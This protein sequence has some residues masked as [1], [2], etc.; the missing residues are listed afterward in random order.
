MVVMLLCDI[1]V[2]ASVPTKVSSRIRFHTIV[3]KTGFEYFG[4]FFKIVIWS[5][6][7]D[8]SIDRSIDRSFEC[9]RIVDVV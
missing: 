2:T 5:L 3:G 8:R 9:C 6:V 4:S 1:D 7:V